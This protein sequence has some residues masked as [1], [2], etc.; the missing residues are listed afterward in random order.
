MK[1]LI[2]YFLNKVSFFLQDQIK[3]ISFK[4]LYE[5]ICSRT[6]S[7][8]N[9]IR[10]IK[11]LKLKN[12]LALCKIIFK[13]FIRSIFNY[14][15]IPLC[16]ST[17][18]IS[19]DL[20]KLQNKIFRHIKFFPIKTRITDMHFKFKLDLIETRSKV[21]IKKFFI[22]KSNH[23]QL[24]S[25]LYEFNL[26]DETLNAKFTSLYL[27]FK[28]IKR[29]FQCCYV[30]Y[31]IKSITNNLPNFIKVNKLKVLTCFKSYFDLFFYLLRLF[32]P[33]N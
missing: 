28:T 30:R 18:K 7:K 22:K 31:I 32:F 1:L 6:T 13:S 12:S 19:S 3:E 20:Q 14:A 33:Y 17:Q 16:C 23:Q 15:F 29:Q 21:L 4:N 11:G 26:L 8:I 10:R 27:D 5:N 25:N 24:R 9:L 2:Y